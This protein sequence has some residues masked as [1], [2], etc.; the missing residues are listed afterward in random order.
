M[1]I[2]MSHAP[3]L[4][5]TAF[6]DAIAIIAAAHELD[7]RFADANHAGSLFVHGA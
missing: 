6:T 1:P 4:I 2:P 5:E 3:I 7:R